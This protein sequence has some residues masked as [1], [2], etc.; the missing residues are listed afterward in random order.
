MFGS[1]RLM[2]IAYVNEQIY[3]KYWINGVWCLCFEPNTLW[4]CSNICCR[5]CDFHMVNCENTS[6]LLTSNNIILSLSQPTH[7]EP[8]FFFVTYT[9]LISF[10]ISFFKGSQ[11]HQFFYLLVNFFIQS[12]HTSSLDGCKYLL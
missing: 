2:F 3:H 8:S 1:Q 6:L 9:Y 5:A 11:I 12:L 7:F 10:A 4:H